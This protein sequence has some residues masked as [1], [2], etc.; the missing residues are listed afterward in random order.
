[1]YDES[2]IRVIQALIDTSTNRDQLFIS[3]FN[4][5]LN[6]QPNITSNPV[7]D[8]QLNIIKSQFFVLNKKYINEKLKNQ[9][10]SICLDEYKSRQH[11]INLK[12]NHG[13][14]KKCI[15]KWFKTYNK[16]C[17]ICRSSPI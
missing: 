17:P 3:N 10:C 11:Y 4:D 16:T 1:M 5:I 14:H 9:T 2:I 8:N 15:V 12:C 6:T 13:F 7:D